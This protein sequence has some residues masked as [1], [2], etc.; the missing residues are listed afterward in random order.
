M[1]VALNFVVPVVVIA[2]LYVA[3]RLKKFWPVVVAV[4]FVVVYTAVQPSYM[5]KGTV[6]ALSSQP[7]QSV[8]TPVVD[9]GLKPKSSEHYDAERNAAIEQ[10]NTNIN[11]IIQDQK[12]K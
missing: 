5:P 11:N 12:T 10:I 2:L 3:F 7:F 8:E 4:L 1:I 9:L 6:K